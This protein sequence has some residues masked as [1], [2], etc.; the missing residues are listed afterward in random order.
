MESVSVL[1]AM[2]L[3]I[4]TRAGTVEA[5]S[6]GAFWGHR[7]QQGITWGH[8]RQGVPHQILQVTCPG[9][10]IGTSVPAVCRNMIEGDGAVVEVQRGGRGHVWARAVLVQLHGAVANDGLLFNGSAHQIRCADRR[11]GH[12]CKTMGTGLD[13]QL[14]EVNRKIQNMII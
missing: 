3:L 13:F 1:T 9:V 7:G 10:S 6:V 5:A 4:H 14:L 12:H 8:R 11:G 2:L